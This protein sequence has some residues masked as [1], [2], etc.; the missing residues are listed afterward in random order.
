MSTTGRVPG[1]FRPGLS[2][3]V[4]RDPAERERLGSVRPGPDY[5]DD[6]F[7]RR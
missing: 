7:A 3:G 2:E 1:Y 5:G 4:H 6:I